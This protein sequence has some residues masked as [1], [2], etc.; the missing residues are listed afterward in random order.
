MLAENRGKAIREWQRRGQL[1]EDR[2]VVGSAAAYLVLSG[3]AGEH[4][5]K[6][7][8]R[9]EVR[10]NVVR[11]TG[12]ADDAAVLEAT[13]V[14]EVKRRVDRYLRTERVGV[15]R[16]RCEHPI[17]ETV[18]AARAVYEHVRRSFAEDPAEAQRQLDAD[19]RIHFQQWWEG[20][21]ESIAAR[22]SNYFQDRARKQ[23][24]AKAD[25]FRARYAQLI[26]D[27]V[28]GLPSRAT[29]ARDRLFDSHSNPVF[30]PSEANH[31]WRTRL[32]HEVM[33]L[34]DRA[35]GELAAELKSDAAALVDFLR[36][37]LLYGSADVGRLLVGSD[38]DFL[39]LL[40]GK[41]QTLFLRFARPVVESLVRLPVADPARKELLNRL[42]ADVNLLDAYF[43][44][45]EPAFRE[46]RAYAK[47][48]RDL[49]VHAPLRDKLLGTATA[50]ADR[51]DR[52]DPSQLPRRAETREEV[53]GEI[54]SDLGALEIYLTCAV[55]AAAGFGAFR[56]QEL[57]R[58][59]SRF[60]AA[61]AAWAGVAQNEDLAG[62]VRLRDRL[63]AH[64]HSTETDIEVCHRLRQ[65]RTSLEA[66]R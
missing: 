31:A 54:E 29:A 19:R 49:L 11:L 17:Q 40:Q 51:I 27:L 30:S 47:Y 35:S 65:L 52:P 15:L 9:A 12:A 10:R 16:K 64:L 62:N 37:V 43:D 5:G 57:E 21:W 2:I 7:L 66:S 20:E 34:I 63:P 23:A 53:I 4:L 55:F 8:D 6:A 56:E 18:E 26:T 33:A 3:L 13:G 22:L 1:P 28:A 39:T 45:D 59:R 14:P 44:G 36:D 32:Y 60:L 61:K 42:G 24:E 46:L 38:R 48:G 50:R 25:P 58:L 41:L